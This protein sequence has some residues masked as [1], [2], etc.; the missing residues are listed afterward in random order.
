MIYEET[1]FAADSLTKTYGKIQAHKPEMLAF[2][3]DVATSDHMKDL[4]RRFL[5]PADVRLG[6]GEDGFED[7]KAH[8]WFA[9]IDWDTLHSA[10]PP[11]IPKLASELDT[12]NF[13]S[14]PDE[15]FTKS[16]EYFVDTRTFNGNQL[17]F[18]GYSYTCDDA[19][20]T[21]ELGT[22]LSKAVSR[23]SGSTIQSQSPE[24]S[25]ESL[26]SRLKL[27]QSEND[28]LKRQVNRQTKLSRTS[29]QSHSEPFTPFQLVRR[30]SSR[31]EFFPD[32][33][34]TKKHILDLEQEVNSLKEEINGI[35][36]RHAAALKEACAN[37]AKRR[38]AAEARVGELETLLA[39]A[40]ATIQ[41]KDHELRSRRRAV[42]RENSR[43]MLSPTF[44]ES[45]DFTLPK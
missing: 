25:P 37:E 10:T 4:L 17:P 14:D 15:G 36:E 24:S 42:M 44:D 21:R 12:S 40:N 18:M 43:S 11:V 2:P 33:K 32:D 5:S 3:L 41:L 29:S 28:D 27:L 9:P 19:F 31:T 16:H 6:A 23:S 7:I 22:P 30:D 34:I 39:A 35:E 38:K 26:M 45:A 8:P 13:P 1:P 20:V